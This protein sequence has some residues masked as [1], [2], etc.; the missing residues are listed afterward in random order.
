MRTDHPLV[1]QH[2]TDIARAEAAVEAGWP[3]VSI[4]LPDLLEW[5]QDYNWPVAH[6]LAPFL[7]TIGLPALPH[8][9]SIL[10]SNDET[11]KYWILAN[12]VAP[13]PEVVAALR[14]DLALI[15]HRRMSSELTEGV[16][17]VAER[18]LHGEPE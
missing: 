5:L 9:K 6:V 8:I 16:V 1:P 10:G 4:V 11:W 2:K 7:A 12:V 13:Q 14:N 18:L 17:E 3:A 15:V